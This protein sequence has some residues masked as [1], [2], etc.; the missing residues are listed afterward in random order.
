[1]APT[2]PTFDEETRFQD[3]DEETSLADTAMLQA[4]AA[5]VVEVLTDLFDAATAATFLE[6]YGVT[7]LERLPLILG[8]RCPPDSSKSVPVTVALHFSG[9]PSWERIP[10]LARQ[11]LTT[12]L[13]RDINVTFV[14][15]QY[16]PDY[17]A[18]ATF[19]SE[20]RYLLEDLRGLMLEQ[21][22]VL[23][24]A[25]TV[26]I[27]D[28][29]RVF[30]T[31]FLPPNAFYAVRP[32]NP[33]DVAATQFVVKMVT[34]NVGGTKEDLR[35]LPSG[36]LR[37]Y[38][39]ETGARPDVF[40]VCLQEVDM[41]YRAAVRPFTA[42]AKRWHKALD[43]EMGS[44]FHCHSFTQV[45][46][47]ALAVFVRSSAKHLFDDRE[48]VEHV[49]FGFLAGV[50]PNKNAQCAFLVLK[51]VGGALS[52]HVFSFQNFHLKNGV[53]E[54]KTRVHQVATAAALSCRLKVD[55]T[56]LIVPAAATV[57]GL[58]GGD[59]NFRVLANPVECEALTR[60][61]GFQRFRAKDELHMALER[62]RSS[63]M[64]KYL[65]DVSPTWPPTYKY[66]PELDGPA[67][68]PS[69]TPGFLDRFFV[70]RPPGSP[71]EAAVLAKGAMGHDTRFALQTDHLGVWIVA[72]F[73]LSS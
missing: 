13:K 10:Q 64:G 7:V 3:S 52:R 32:A 2:S 43:A 42:A 24:A 50:L 45:M 21:S 51:T 8:A 39:A 56:H 73:F 12:M 31:P 47:N 18:E 14:K 72:R 63:G 71:W 30:T 28:V 55:G 36:W 17:D 69:R 19:E 59:S 26:E 65:T 44:T 9:T 25:V 20:L 53:T 35:A 15:I 58:W 22:E 67:V 5:P 41:S 16:S 34:M 70:H 57:G 29:P 27:R 66:F 11:F 49:K 33:Q 37:K 38:G 48:R 61:E 54:A 40:V 1:M 6:K 62:Y 46:G 4:L 60:L 23:E 68:D